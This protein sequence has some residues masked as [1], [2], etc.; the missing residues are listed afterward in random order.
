MNIRPIEDRDIPEVVGIMLRNWDGVMSQHHSPAVVSRFR[1]EVTPDWLRRQMAWKRIFVVEDADG[2]VASG[3]LA[4]FGDKGKPKYCVSQFFVRPDLHGRGIGGLLMGHILLAARDAGVELL[5]VPSSRNAVPFYRKAGFSICGE[6]PDAADEITW[7]SAN[8]FAIRRFADEDAGHVARLVTDN[9]LLVNVREYGEG[10]AKE[11][12]S[13]YSPDLIREYARNGEMYVAV[14]GTRIAGTA[15]LERDRIR[16]VFVRMDRHGRG[17][18]GALMQRVEEI[19][20]DGGLKR[21][22]LQANS[23]AVEFYRRLG[24][25]RLG[26]I[27]ERVGSFAIRM[28]EMEKT[29]L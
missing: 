14:E 8:I 7:M 2:I 3:G 28:I 20:R 10:A 26:E 24:Y 15:T 11:L 6:Q 19:A 5:H 12:A 13:F 23:A 21:L 4:D 9:L 25:V 18:G 17:I 29:P 22:R 16:N 1:G 27:D